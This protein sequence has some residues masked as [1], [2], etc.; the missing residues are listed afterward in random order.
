MRISALRDSG[1]SRF[2]TNGTDTLD[3]TQGASWH[4]EVDNLG[5]ALKLA[6]LQSAAFSVE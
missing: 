2:F 1:R 3:L 5:L 6:N 4:G